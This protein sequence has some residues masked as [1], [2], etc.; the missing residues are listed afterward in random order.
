MTDT[1]LLLLAG[2][3]RARAKEILAQAEIMYDAEAKQNLH[4]IVLRYETLAHRVEFRAY[5]S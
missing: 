5:D 2:H 4:E 3:L 1:Q